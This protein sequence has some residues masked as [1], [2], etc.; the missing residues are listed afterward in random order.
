MEKIKAMDELM[1]IDQSSDG[2]EPFDARDRSVTPV[3]AESPL[4]DDNNEGKKTV[5]GVSN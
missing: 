1:Q 3:S 4:N 2:T 5:N